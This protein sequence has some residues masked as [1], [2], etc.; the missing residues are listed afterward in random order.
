MYLNFFFQAEDGIR[1][2]SVTG[3]QT[4]ALPISQNVPQQTAPPPQVRAVLVPEPSLAA[5][6]VPADAQLPDRVF[7]SGHT[8]AVTAVA[9]SP[10]R[11]WAATGGEDKT[12]R[13]WDLASSSEQRV[14]TG[15]TDRL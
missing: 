3:V 15:H 4:C 6:P 10:D 2:S 14:L 13:V 11:R 8:S 9:F 7:A 1:D 5:Q 12:I